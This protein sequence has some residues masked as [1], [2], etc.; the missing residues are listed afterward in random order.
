LL[1]QKISGT[2]T[3]FLGSFGTSVCLDVKIG[4]SVYVDEKHFLCLNSS[5]IDQLRS[6][7]SGKGLLAGEGLTMYQISGP[8]TVYVTTQQP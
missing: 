5:A 1:L 4:T 2:G 6:T 7:F 8:A 3:V